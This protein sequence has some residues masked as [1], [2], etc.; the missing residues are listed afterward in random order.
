VKKENKMLF[1]RINRSNPEKIF[2]TVY[3]DYGTAAITVGMPVIWDY[4]GTADGVSVTKPTAESGIA[5]AGVVADASIASGSYGL[6]QVWG[7]NADAIVDGGTDVAAGDGITMN[8]A[9]FELYMCSTASTAVLDVPCGFAY[10]GITAATA[11]ATAVHL[12]C[13]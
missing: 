3:N 13:L 2:M 7:Y 6:I 5:A 12:K 11:A 8:A 1:S 10:A 4:A 9:E